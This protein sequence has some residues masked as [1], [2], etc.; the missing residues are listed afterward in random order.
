MVATL[1][2]EASAAR[3]ESSSLSPPTI[4]QAGVAQLAE[5]LPSKQDV[6]SS[7]LVSRSN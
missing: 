1:V 7:N 2:L 4:T 5:H 6:A 3:R